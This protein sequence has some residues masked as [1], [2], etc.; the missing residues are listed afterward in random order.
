MRLFTSFPKPSDLCFLIKFVQ[1]AGWFS[2]S[3]SKFNTIVTGEIRA[4]FSGS[5]YI[6]GGNDMV[7]EI[8]INTFYRMAVC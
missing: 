3:V 4:G 2:R 7:E 1:V 8:Y 6:I 5:Q